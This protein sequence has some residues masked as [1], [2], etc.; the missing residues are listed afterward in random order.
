LINFGIE[1]K[2]NKWGQPSILGSGIMYFD[3][4]IFF[5]NII[6][7]NVLPQLVKIREIKGINLRRALTIVENKIS[8]IAMTE[9][10]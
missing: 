1:G 10:P 3:S 4:F 6:G 8:P 5:G 2:G 7:E 9:G